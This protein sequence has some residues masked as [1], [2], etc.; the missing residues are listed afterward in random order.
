MKPHHHMG[1][2]AHLT[3]EIPML[4]NKFL[5]EATLADQQGQ[6]QVLGGHHQIIQII[7]NLKP[8]ASDQNLKMVVE[9]PKDI[10]PTSIEQELYL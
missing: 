10:G 4:L 3:K 9:I 6:V 7:I 5:E 1:Y 2:L 8:M